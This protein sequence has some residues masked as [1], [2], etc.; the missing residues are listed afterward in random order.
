MESPDIEQVAQDITVALL[1]LMTENETFSE[2][3]LAIAQDQILSAKT[4][5]ELVTI[6]IRFKKERQASLNAVRKLVDS[7]GGQK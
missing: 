3:L 5:R 1:E 2:A 7:F 6:I 4:R